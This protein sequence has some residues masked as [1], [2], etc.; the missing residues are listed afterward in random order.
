MLRSCD[1]MLALILLQKSD[2]KNVQQR[3]HRYL[4]IWSISKLLSTYFSLPSALDKQEPPC[5]LLVTSSA[6]CLLVEFLGRT[7]SMGC[8]SSLFQYIIIYTE[9]PHDFRLFFQW[10]LAYQTK[11]KLKIN[12]NQHSQIWPLTFH[13]L[14][15]QMRCI[16]K[17]GQTRCSASCSSARQSASRSNGLDR[18]GQKLPCQLGYTYYT[19]VHEQPIICQAYKSPSAVSK[20]LGSWWG[21]T[22]CRYYLTQ[23][24]PWTLPHPAHF[25]LHSKLP[26]LKRSQNMR[27]PRPT[28]DSSFWAFFLGWYCDTY[29]T[30]DRV[31]LQRPFH[32]IDRT[33]SLDFEVCL[34]VGLRISLASE[35]LT[36]LENTL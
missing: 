4:R 8:E 35:C 5:H 17:R 6:T 19:T 22:T 28:V 13:V 18:L 25:S 7:L 9:D 30:S 20:K 3:Y 33:R 12:E 16:G 15:H 11:L 34:V 27:G 32:I 31:S 24:T 10:R 36:D 1:P 26:G 14:R 23:W 21:I 2:D 29:S